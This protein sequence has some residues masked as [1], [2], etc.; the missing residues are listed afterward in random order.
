MVVY[1]HV[2][3]IASKGSLIA[4]ALATNWIKLR[5]SRYKLGASWSA[6]WDFSAPVL[7]LKKWVQ[8][9]VAVTVLF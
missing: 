7:L 5:A 2:L 6:G 3:N 1:S 9:S 4:A 8:E